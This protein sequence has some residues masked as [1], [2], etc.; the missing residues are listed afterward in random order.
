MS[1]FKVSELEALG[2]DPSDS[3]VFL[4]ND[5]STP[6]NP[7]TRAINFKQLSDTIV[8]MATDPGTPAPT[9]EDQGN[10]LRQSILD[11]IQKIDVYIDEEEEKDAPDASLISN[12]KDYR[13]EIFELTGNTGTY[14][15][16]KAE[17]ARITALVTA[18]DSIGA[19]RFQFE[20]DAGLPEFVTQDIF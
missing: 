7:F 11:T 20:L 19:K 17:I 3:D 9:V 8:A 12:L 5:N 13:T 10:E 2:R 1:T 14:D 6:S 16:I 18:V 15:Q 4:I